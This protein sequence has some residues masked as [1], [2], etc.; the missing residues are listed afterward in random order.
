MDTSTYQDLSGR[1]ARLELQTGQRDQSGLSLAAQVSNLQGKVESLYRSNAELQTLERIIETVRDPKKHIPEIKNRNVDVSET[2]KQELLLAKFP[3][4]REAY[5][6]L[7]EL[8]TLDIPAISAEAVD[9]VDLAS[10]KAREDAIEKI[11][12]AYHMM[13]VKNSIV[14]EKYMALMERENEFW[15]D[16][17]KK[18]NSMR[19]RLDG[20]ENKEIMDRRV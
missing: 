6:N 12:K 3:A 17:E 2:E 18:F 10:V 7:A 20:L 4:I 19:M 9:K 14:F 5:A 8:S 1:L 13:V 15:V 11:M 16:V